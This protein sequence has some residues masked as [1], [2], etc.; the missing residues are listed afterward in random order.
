M[1]EKGIVLDQSR[2]A[3]IVDVEGMARLM[4]AKCV[5]DMNIDIIEIAWERE[6]EREGN[7]IEKGN[8]KKGQEG[9]STTAQFPIEL[10]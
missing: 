9:L 4:Y 10:V 3:E 5:F 8:K 7:E 1:T 2:S 6:R